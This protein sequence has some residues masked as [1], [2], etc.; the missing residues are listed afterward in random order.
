MEDFEKDLMDIIL[1]TQ[2]IIQK[3][4]DIIHIHKNAKHNK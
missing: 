3:S 2:K 1:K 4:N